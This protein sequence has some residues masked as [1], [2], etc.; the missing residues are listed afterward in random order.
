VYTVFANLRGAWTELT[1]DDAINGQVPSRYDI[2][3]LFPVIDFNDQSEREKSFVEIVHDG[4]KC[5]V[6]AACLQFFGEE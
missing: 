4:I 6:H 1:D 5:Y 2:H 3:S